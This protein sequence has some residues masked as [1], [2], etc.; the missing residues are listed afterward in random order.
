MQELQFLQARLQAARVGPDAAGPTRCAV[1]PGTLAGRLVLVDQGAG[2]LALEFLYRGFTIPFGAG[3]ALGEKAHAA[4]QVGAAGHRR[5]LLVQAI[6]RPGQI[7]LGAPVLRPFAQ[8]GLVGLGRGQ[9][10]AQGIVG[11]AQVVQGVVSFRGRAREQQGRAEVALRGRVVLEPPGGGTGAG[12][13]EI[14]ANPFEPGLRLGVAA[15]AIFAP[16]GVQGIVGLR[17]VRGQ[18][19]QAGDQQRRRLRQRPWQVQPEQEQQGRRQ[20]PGIEFAPGPH[21]IGRWRRGRQAGE[22]VVVEAGPVGIAVD[23]GNEDAAGALGQFAVAGRGHAADDL[24]A[25]L[26]GVA[27]LGQ[28]HRRAAGAADAEHI[29]RD[30][31]R[32]QILHRRA[33]RLAGGAGQAVG[34]GV[35]HQQDGAALADIALGELQGGGEVGAGGGDQRR[36]DLIEHAPQKIG[37]V[38]RRAE[39][40]GLAGIDDEADAFALQSADEVVQFQLGAHQS[41]WTDIGRVHRG[42]DIEHDGDA[43][44]MALAGLAIARVLFQRQ[45]RSGG[46]RRQQGPGEEVAGQAPARHR[47]RAAAQYRPR[48]QG[49]IGISGQPVS[50][51]MAQT[52]HEQGLQGEQTPEGLAPV[53]GE[54]FAHASRLSANARPSDSRAAARASGSQYHSRI[55]RCLAGRARVFSKAPMSRMTRSASSVPRTK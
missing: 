49:R 2:F 32:F 10:V 5:A 9:P 52:P 11:V 7:G 17:L 3:D 31:G 45:A 36:F 54:Q 18:G 1:E 14:A 46:G 25:V 8:H 24:H 26:L 21:R 37:I 50:A 38:A 35:G 27:P 33:H 29:K 12:L 42:R 41:A 23:G 48:Q 15:G 22:V 30:A 4:A 19:D 44:R 47:P 53:E 20:A 34:L 51:P 39:Q 55:S 43:Q 13:A 16:G 28:G 40:A 6:D